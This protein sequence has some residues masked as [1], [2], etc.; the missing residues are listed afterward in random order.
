MVASRVTSRLIEA[1][2]A[3]LLGVAVSVP[4]HASDLTAPR[5]SERR[6]LGHS[7]D[8]PLAADA[9][10]QV[11]ETLA[12][13]RG[14][15]RAQG[16]VRVI[17]GVR[18]AF[19]PEGNL[20]DAEVRVQRDDI[21]N[22]Q[23]HIHGR[24]PKQAADKVT[25]FEFIPFTAME[26]DADELETLAGMP[27]VTDI[28]E[29][30]LSKPMLAESVPL[31]RGNAAW[32][33]G[34]TGN[35]WSVAVLD[36]GVDKTHPFLSGKVVSEACYSTTNNL[37]GSTS[38]CPGG[39]TASTA[40]GSGLNCSISIEGCKHGTHVAG[41]AAGLGTAFSGVAKGANIIAIQVFHRVDNASVCGNSTPCALS[42]ER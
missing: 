28:Q 15:A 2:A 26:V 13:L 21:A 9:D 7:I 30:R 31:I 35:G 32:A 12:E 6:L 18:A 37:Y 25:H 34:Y 29:D 23:R 5:Q 3:V 20:S 4:V 1:L 36:S 38:V 16:K 14:K 41:I 8:G 33:A 40:T 42:Y 19:A 11:R 27:E 10:P 39:V 17:I 22:V 24:L